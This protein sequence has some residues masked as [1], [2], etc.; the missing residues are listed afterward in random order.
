MNV[1]FQNHEQQEYIQRRI[2]GEI[3]QPVDEDNCLNYYLFEES[4][5]LDQIFNWEQNIQ[6]ATNR[7]F[8]QFLMI[9]YSVDRQECNKNS[10]YVNGPKYKKN[11]RVQE[12]ELKKYIIDIPYYKE[13]SPDAYI[14]H[15]RNHNIKDQLFFNWKKGYDIKTYCLRMDQVNKK[16]Q[17]VT[18]KIMLH[19]CVG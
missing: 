13:M 1:L 10:V 4:W 8:D 19:G 9:N 18:S 15:T 5:I 14:C 3:D 16:D 6:V 12:L 2:E 7:K 11:L 17:V